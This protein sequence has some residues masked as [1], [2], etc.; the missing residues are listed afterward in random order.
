MVDRVCG[1]RGAVALVRGEAG[2]GKTSLLRALR[3]RAGLPFYVGRCEPLSVPEPLGPLHELF[4]AAGAPGTLESIGGDRRSLARSLQAAL[5]SGGPAIAAV[6]DAHWADPATLDVVRVMARRAEDVPLGL[7]LTLR[8][9]ELAANRPL[10]VLVG[11]LA[12]DPE[13]VRIALAALS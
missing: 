12:T 2:I 6:E 13:I 7:V 1:G 5:T 3:D 11:D 8:D 9:D 10:A 4:A